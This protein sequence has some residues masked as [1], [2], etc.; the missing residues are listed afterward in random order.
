LLEAVEIV[1]NFGEVIRELSEPLSKSI[2]NGFEMICRIFRIVSYAAN[3]LEIATSSKIIAKTLELMANANIYEIMLKCIIGTDVE[4]ELK[5]AA[6]KT[7]SFVTCCFRFKF[8]D[9]DGINFVRNNQ[10]LKINLFHPEFLKILSVI[11]CDNCIDT[12]Y[13]ALLSLAFIVEIDDE[14]RNILIQLKLVEN[15]SPLITADKLDWS[16]FEAIG[17][18]VSSLVSCLSFAF[19]SALDKSFLVT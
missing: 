2:Q 3:P 14:S 18:F 16:H 1:N 10:F 19:N 4:S 17:C 12:R 7:L 9:F 13:Q 5:L 11:S 8:A 15:L 6:L